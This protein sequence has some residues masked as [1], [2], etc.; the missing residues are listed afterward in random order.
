[1][2]FAR[3]YRAVCTYSRAA[4]IIL[5]NGLTS[6]GI[7]RHAMLALLPLVPYY[8]SVRMNIICLHSALISPQAHNDATRPGTHLNIAVTHPVFDVLECIMHAGH[9]Y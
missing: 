5:S 6:I 9:E 8:L 4:T 1:M 7:P 2:T 3:D